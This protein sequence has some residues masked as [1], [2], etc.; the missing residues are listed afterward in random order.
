M[1][2]QRQEQLE[3]LEPELER[4]LHPDFQRLRRVELVATAFLRCF[5]LQLLLRRELLELLQWSLLRQKKKLQ[6]L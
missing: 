1:L 5:R 2:Q 4:R 6:E 3:L